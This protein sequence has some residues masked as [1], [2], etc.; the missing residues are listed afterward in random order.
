LLGA[1]APKTDDGRI[2]GARRAVPPSRAEE[3]RNWRREG[4]AEGLVMGNED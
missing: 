2:V 1:L 4:R 3:R